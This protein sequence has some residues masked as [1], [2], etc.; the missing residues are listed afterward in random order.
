MV[1]FFYDI[2]LFYYITVRSIYFHLLFKDLNNE[3]T[4]TWIRCNVRLQK[5]YSE[6]SAA[7]VFTLRIRLVFF[8]C[9]LRFRYGFRLL[10]L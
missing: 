10:S 8:Y 3:V 6:T 2:F 1:C 7:A 4:S 5:G 9:F